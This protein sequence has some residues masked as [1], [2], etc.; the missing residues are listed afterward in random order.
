MMTQH[1]QTGLKIMPPVKCDLEEVTAV[2]SEMCSLRL[3]HPPPSSSGRPL[4][5]AQGSEPDLYRC[6]WSTG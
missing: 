3:V 1:K 4:C 5:N 2:Y 6:I